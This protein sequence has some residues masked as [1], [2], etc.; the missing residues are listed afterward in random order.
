MRIGSTAVEA[1]AKFQIYMII[2]KIHMIISITK[3]PASVAH[4]I[5]QWDLLSDIETYPWSFYW[6]RTCV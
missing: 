1:P 5:F 2:S 3:F 4:K 6:G